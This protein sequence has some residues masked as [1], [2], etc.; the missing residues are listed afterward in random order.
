MATQVLGQIAPH[1]GTVTSHRSVHAVHTTVATVDTITAESLGLSKVLG[2]VASLGS[3]AGD[4]LINVTA[5]VANNSVVLKTWKHDGS[6][7]TPVAATVFSKRVHLAVF[8]Y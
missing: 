8:G 5:D 7:P 2:V 4:A 1:G 3:D 6:D